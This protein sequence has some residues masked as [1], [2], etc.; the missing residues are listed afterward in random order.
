MLSFFLKLVDIQDS[1]E[2]ILL[3]FPDI[4]PFL[5]TAPQRITVDLGQ[6]VRIPCPAHGASYGAVYSWSG[7]E[8]LE[9]PINARRA[10]S[11]AGELFIMYVTQEDITKIEQLKGISCTITGAN[12][13]YKSRRITLVKS[14]NNL[15]HNTLY[16]GIHAE[17]IVYI[18]CLFAYDFAHGR[19]LVRC[20]L[21]PGN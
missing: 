9:F 11:A 1:S 8:N 15:L 19:K 20:I 3:L 5:S 14:G 2:L 6:S 21:T 17:V 13:I 18:F 7:D 4:R 16:R 10:I 12:T